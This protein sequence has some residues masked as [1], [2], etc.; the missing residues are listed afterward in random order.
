MTIISIESPKIV[1]GTYFG[2]IW[3][4]FLELLRVAGI[5]DLVICVKLFQNFLKLFRCWFY[6]M[7]AIYTPLILEHLYIS[8][9]SYAQIIE[10]SNENFVDGYGSN[11][12]KHNYHFAMKLSGAWKGNNNETKL[13]QINAGYYLLLKEVSSFSGQGK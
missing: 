5:V 1:P 10:P 4:N 9:P 2:P 7:E 8:Y 3:P 12:V 6:G 11:L 13:G